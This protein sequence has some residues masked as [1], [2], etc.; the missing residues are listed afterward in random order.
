MTGVYT[1]QN[2]LQEFRHHCLQL[3]VLK[4]INDKWKFQSWL[5]GQSGTLLF[6]ALCKIRRSRSSCIS[7]PVPYWSKFCAFNLGRI[8]AKN[9]VLARS[10]ALAKRLMFSSSSAAWLFF[11]RAKN[12]RVSKQICLT[13]IHHIATLV[14]IV[15]SNLM[16]VQVSQRR[17]ILSYATYKTIVWYVF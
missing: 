12:F 13:N 10:C 1:W 16:C 6:K 4:L 9:D 15:K 14:T 8:T 2:K 11:L 17:T 3:R 7:F 5:S